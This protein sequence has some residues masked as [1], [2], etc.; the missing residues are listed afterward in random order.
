MKTILLDRSNTPL[1]ETNGNGLSTFNIIGNP[2]SISQLVKLRLMMVRRETQFQPQNTID[3][4]AMM[5]R[6]NT[7]NVLATK[8]RALISQTQEVT[9]VDLSHTQYDLDHT[10]KLTGVC[11]SVGCD[12]V[13]VGI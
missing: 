12:K 3:W 6:K 5:N 4:F 9:D 8:I 7:R 13:E 1:I 10:I 2:Q 11:F